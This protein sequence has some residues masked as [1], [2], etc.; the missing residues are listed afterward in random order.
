M[1]IELYC[2][3]CGQHM[4]I[5]DQY[6]GQ[7]GT[8]RK[9]GGKITVPQLAGDLP[10]EEPA[11]SDKRN[12]WLPLSIGG[13][14]VL[15]LAGGFA[16]FVGKGSPDSSPE[17]EVAHQQQAPKSPAEQLTDAQQLAIRDRKYREGID[18]FERIRAQYPDAV[19]SRHSLYISLAYAAIDDH[20]GHE[21]LCRWTLDRF[22]SSYDP[23][24]AERVAKAY[25]LYPGADDP[26][27]LA[28][29]ERLTELAVNS[30]S[31]TSDSWNYLAHGMAKYRLGKFDEANTWLTKA[32]DDNRP[33]LRAQVRAYAILTE[34]GLGNESAAFELFRQLKTDMNAAPAPVWKD[35]VLVELAMAEAESLIG[36]SEATNAES[37][38]LNNRPP[39]QMYDDARDLAIEGQF[40]ESARLFEEIRNKNP[41]ALTHGN[42]QLPGAVYVAAGEHALH[43]S[44]T[45]WVFARFRNN[46]D[47]YEL[48]HGAKLYLIS[49]R[50]S[51]PEL[52]R[53]CSRRAVR[54]TEVARGPVR[55]WVYVV[56]GMSEYRLGNVEAAVTWLAKTSENEVPARRGL[57]S[58][59]Y[60]MA[61]YRLGN[62]ELAQELLQQAKSALSQMPRS[63]SEQ[64]K[65]GW[66][67][68]LYI[69]LAIQEAE[70]LLESGESRRQ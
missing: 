10:I 17:P 69:D 42:A 23:T 57:T 67:G 2:Q 63:G 53:E 34:I 8:C 14:V 40:G 20:V 33:G 68:R 31:G 1:T 47:P 18:A 4:Q 70:R 32:M 36:S 66:D 62:S 45:R 25:L 52:L 61:V 43:E 11:K 44:F 48:E 59:F 3:H 46:D 50:A 13:I 39:E 35:D 15:L 65:Q 12:P 41:E 54:A 29:A 55:F 51:D 9:C 38:L 27:L 19:T 21:Q 60:S 49:P 64:Y 22:S 24:D 5:D 7:M 37:A 30:E 28:R 6:A 56:R 16:L 58:A 26:A